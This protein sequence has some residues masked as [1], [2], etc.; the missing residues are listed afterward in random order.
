[1]VSPSEMAPPTRASFGAANPRMVLAGTLLM[2]GLAAVPFS[3]KTVR[4]RERKVHEM[5]DGNLD[6]KDAARNARLRVK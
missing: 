2:L 6:E 5:R 1:M 3:F 4:E